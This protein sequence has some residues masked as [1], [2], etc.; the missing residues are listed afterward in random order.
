VY[1]IKAI[2]DKWYINIDKS[3]MEDLCSSIQ[4][5][6]SGTRTKV[7][8]KQFSG[9]SCNIPSNVDII[10]LRSQRGIKGAKRLGQFKSV[11]LEI[12]DSFAQSTFFKHGLRVG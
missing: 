8:S 10:V 4:N 1:S 3:A 6:I 5:I 12:L 2:S 11:K 9:I 7:T